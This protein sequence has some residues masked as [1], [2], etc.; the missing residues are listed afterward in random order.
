MQII[1]LKH[2]FNFLDF[3]FIKKVLLNKNFFIIE[4][5]NKNLN[6]YNK[7]NFIFIKKNKVLLSFNSF[8]FK[9]SYV[10][11][12]TF[13]KIEMLLKYDVTYLLY[14]KIKNWYFNNIANFLFFKKNFEIFSIILKIL[15]KNITFL[16]LLKILIKK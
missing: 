1:K 8:C 13:S 6:K 5:Q 9:S 15:I 11:L 14:I 7:K 2:T 4:Y 3:L 12:Q 16:K 10:Y